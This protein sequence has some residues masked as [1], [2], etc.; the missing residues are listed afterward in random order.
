MKRIS[1]F[2]ASLILCVNAFA[3][4]LTSKDLEQV[5][6]SVRAELVRQIC[7]IAE[8]SDTA[9]LN[10]IDN[11]SLKS[12]KEE[13]GKFCTT[14]NDEARKTELSK[15][16]QIIKDLPSLSGNDVD[17]YFT[18]LNKAISSTVSSLSVN[19]KERAETIHDIQTR[20]NDLL[21]FVTNEL[22]AEITSDNP[23]ETVIGNA[24]AKLNQPKEVAVEAVAII[25]Q[26]V[27]QEQAKA[28]DKKD[29]K[30]KKA[31]KEKNDKNEKKDKEDNEKEDKKN[32]KLIGLFFLAAVGYFYYTR[33]YKPT[34]PKGDKQP[35]P[36]HTEDNTH[37]D[38]HGQDHAPHKDDD[39]HEHGGNDKPEDP[40]EEV[41]LTKVRTSFAEE[42]E[43][44]SVV[45]ASV[46]GIS[47]IQ[48]KK[49][50]QDCC[51]YEK[52][53]NGWGI[54]ITSDGA[55][56][57][58][59]S[60]VGSRIVVERGIAHFKQRILKWM[61][62]NTLPTDAEWMQA[63]YFAFKSV[64][65]DMKM[66]A[67]KN[68]KPLS[69]L[70][71]TAIVLVHTPKG[72]LVSHVGDGRAGYADSNGIWKSAIVPHKGEEA[73]QTIFMTSDFWNLPN[74]V[75]SGVFVPESRVIREVPS[76]FALMS[77]GCENNCWLC[78]RYDEAQQKY[79]DPNQPYD[80]FFA[81][82]CSS[83]ESMRN[84]NESLDERKLKWATYL[85]SAG[86]FAKEPDDKT[87]IVGILKY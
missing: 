48:M 16:N 2:I 72:I 51:G 22:N 68:G 65:D 50:C 6:G 81:S 24:F 42:S 18:K 45:G 58:E 25:P 49:P 38:D 74:Y 17:E 73:N 71:A 53:E 12:F 56:S 70:A 47:H 30:D 8:I 26:E 23:A 62:A 43:S 84:A 9:V 61:L 3:G 69:S 41:D 64:Y 75:M 34:S 54:A 29:K 28:Q 83:I 27:A 14:E 10:S 36:V 7:D 46:I 80:K 77:D 85:L 31:T 86:K 87:M 60:E 1:L 55:G 67:E 32:G 35:K 66:V 82:I 52:L 57:A 79:C 19:Y 44:A 59:H 5:F 40:V 20:L 39:H 13:F 33:Y 21:F 63:A 15:I 11:L 4:N 78:N 76:A 37:A